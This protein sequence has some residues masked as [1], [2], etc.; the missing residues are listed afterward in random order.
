M[1]TMS[2][3][4]ESSISTK[5]SDEN[6]SP[7]GFVP[8]EKRL[9]SDLRWALTEASLFFDE[10]GN[11]HQALRKITKR[12]DELGISYSVV[13]GLALFRHGYRRFTEDVDLLVTREALRA[14]HEKLDGLGYQP[15]FSQSK[16]LRDTELGVKIEFLVT[17]AYPG[18][19]KPKPVAF[20]D[21][22]VASVEQNGIRYLNLNTLVE[23]KLASGMTAPGRMKDLSDVVELIKA[24]NLPREF[25]DRLDPYVRDKFV[26][27]WASARRRFVRLWRNKFLTI[28][29]K[30]LDE[31]IASLSAAAAELERMKNDGVTLEPDGGTGD[32]YAH[33]VTTDP[34]VAEKYGMMDE[35]EFWGESE[36]DTQTSE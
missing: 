4:S 35:S 16:N 25:A 27:L 23:L 3:I 5:A 15:P 19:G 8:Y 9:S 13:G 7:G 10:K 2:R 30:S 24:L 28:H 12:L 18:D 21:P 14:I 6:G 34:K 26:E 36:E 32:D 29:A 33:L 31:M 1:Q 22:A 20:P 17:G 11:V